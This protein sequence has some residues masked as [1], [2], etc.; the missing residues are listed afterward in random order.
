M[1][2]PMRTGRFRRCHQL[3]T[4]GLG[5]TIARVSQHGIGICS[6]SPA[7]LPAWHALAGKDDLVDPT[8]VAVVGTLVGALAGAG[9]TLVARHQADAAADKRAL[10]QRRAN[11]RELLRRAINVFIERTQHAERISGEKIHPDAVKSEAAHALWVSHKQLTLIC[12]E[13]LSHHADELAQV[14][15]RYM[16]HPQDQPV[17]EVASNVTQRFRR[18]A[19]EE[20]RRLS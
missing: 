17:W 13:D 12:S 1:G 3:Q 4:V 20:I 10:E 11:D 7:G 15:H 16:W 6:S 8:V 18:A 14:L 9:G 2:A 5:G 19:R